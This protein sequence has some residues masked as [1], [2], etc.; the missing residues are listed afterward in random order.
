MRLAALALVAAFALAPATAEARRVRLKSTRDPVATLA[1]WQARAVQHA[2]HGAR[3][4]ECTKHGLSIAR[5][6]FKQKAMGARGKGIFAGRDPVTNEHK[7]VHLELVSEQAG[8]FTI[9]TEHIAGDVDGASTTRVFQPGA[10][11]GQLVSTDG[12]ARVLLIPGRGFFD[13]HDESF[14]G[15]PE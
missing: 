1:R 11:R 15:D 2:A 14:V 8:T 13:Y 9:K 6:L 12:R 4:A 10:T 7:V 3:C 5:A